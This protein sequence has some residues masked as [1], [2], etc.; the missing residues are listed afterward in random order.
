MLFGIKAANFNKAV[1]NSKTRIEH[2]SQFKLIEEN[3]WIDS[4]SEDNIV[5]IMK[6][7][8]KD[9]RKTQLKKQLRNI[10]LSQNIRTHCSSLL[11][12]EID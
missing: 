8:F 3:K 6:K 7:K 9:Q 11:P 2:N 10:S 1:S 12:Y 5:T 4:R